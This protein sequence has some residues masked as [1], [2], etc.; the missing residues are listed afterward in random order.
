MQY[1]VIRK[2]LGGPELGTVLETTDRGELHIREATQADRYIV[3]SSMQ[4]LLD[5][6]YI[7]EVEGKW[8]PGVGHGYSYIDEFGRI[9]ACVRSD[10]NDDRRIE[11]GNYFETPNKALKVRDAIKE[12]LKQI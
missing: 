11:F 4:L 1:K 10:V 2:F 3:P 9:K 8:K 6:G 5:G 7:E 12:L